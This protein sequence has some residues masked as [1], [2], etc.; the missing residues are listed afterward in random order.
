MSKTTWMI[1]TALA[2]AVST[3]VIAHDGVTNSAAGARMDGM[4]VIAQNMKTIGGMAQG[5]I[6]FD[7]NAAQA[8]I[9]AIASQAA[10]VPALFKADETDPKSKASATIWTNWGDFTQKAAAL[11]TTADGVDVSSAASLGQAMGGLG[12]SCKSCH[13]SYRI[14]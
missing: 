11:K 14:K 12:G 13:K 2:I 9:D 10:N 5:Q 1:S 3:A 4:A 7:T 6:A 8:A